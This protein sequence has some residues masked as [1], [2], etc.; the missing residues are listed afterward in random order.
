MRGQH[1]YDGV[2]GS[3]KS[4]SGSEDL[5]LKIFLLP[6]FHRHRRCFGSNLIRLCVCVC[7]Y[8]CD[9]EQ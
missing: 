6:F 3:N 5:Q 8:V 9:G 2:D 4:S 7:V 1:R